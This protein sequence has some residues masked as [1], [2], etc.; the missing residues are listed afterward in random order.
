MTKEL[1]LGS[2]NKSIHQ[3]FS[4]ENVPLKIFNIFSS[5]HS[6]TNIMPFFWY[7]PFLALF[8]DRDPHL[9]LVMALRDFFLLSHFPRPIG[10]YSRR[11]SDDCQMSMISNKYFYQFFVCGLFHVNERS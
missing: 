8:G 2:A 7:L 11:L 6:T 10:I 3:M 9:D 5:K 4:T 1:H